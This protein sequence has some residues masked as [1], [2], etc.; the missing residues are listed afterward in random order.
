MS[1]HP[2]SSKKLP[3]VAEAAQHEPAEAAQYEP[4]EAV[5][6]EPA[7]AVAAEAVQSSEAAEAAGSAGNG[8]LWAGSVSASW[9]RAS[10]LADGLMR[11]Q[12]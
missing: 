12:Q 8:R 11:D 9:G 4:A 7:E 6:Y 5:Q 10:A 2:D 1:E 3:D